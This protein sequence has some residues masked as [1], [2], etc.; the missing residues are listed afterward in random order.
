MIQKLF[1]YQLFPKEWLS[2]T[3]NCQFHLKKE[4]WEINL[5]SNCSLNKHVFFFY[6]HCTQPSA[7]YLLN[8]STKFLPWKIKSK[9]NTKQRTKLILHWC[10]HNL[11]N[12]SI[13][14]GKWVGTKGCRGKKKGKCF[15]TWNAS[16]WWKMVWTAY[17]ISNETD[18]HL[19]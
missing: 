12:T 5:C 6:L 14:V 19:H 17:I 9:T 10:L 2:V 16:L 4:N 1:L 3:Y 18:S 11:L 7:Y 8:T 13:L 15:K